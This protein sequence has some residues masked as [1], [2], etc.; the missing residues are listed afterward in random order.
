MAHEQNGN[1]GRDTNYAQTQQHGHIGYGHFLVPNLPA[2]E[3]NR[4]PDMAPLPG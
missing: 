1:G 2:A 3:I 4:V